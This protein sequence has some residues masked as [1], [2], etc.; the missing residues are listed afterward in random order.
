MFE[1]EGQ[2]QI[3]PDQ[4]HHAKELLAHTEDSGEPG[5]I[6]QENMG[7]GKTKVILPML[8]LQQADKSCVVSTDVYL[9]LTKQQTGRRSFVSAYVTQVE[10]P[11]ASAAVTACC[12]HT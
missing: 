4:Y 10:P 9:H 2:L 6:V 1:V 11:A 12:Q 5:P 3:R 7:G 8:A